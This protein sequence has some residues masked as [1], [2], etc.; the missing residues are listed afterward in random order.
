VG[1]SSALRSARGRPILAAVD[2]RSDVT[3][4]PATAADYEAFARLQPQ[5][6]TGDPIAPFDRF[7]RELAPT[8]LV[9]E[10]AG[11]VVGYSWFEVLAGTGY[12]RHVVVDAESRG[13][14]A[15]RALMLG[16]RARLRAAGCATWCLNVRPDNVPA[17]R[18][19]ESLGLTAA[20]D[21]VALR[22]TWPL[23]DELPLGAPLE[24]VVAP[25]AAQDAAIE[26]AFGLVAG[27]LAAARARAGRVIVAARRDDRLVGAAVFDPSFPGAFPFR[28]L[29]AADARR[30]LEG[31][32]PLARPGVP[33][34]GVVV[35]DHPALE[36]LLLG[37]GAEVRFR[38]VH[39]R[40]SLAAP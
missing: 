7:A 22:F 38:I 16:V 9:A 6:G 11:R 19:Y 36:A 12:V 3:L 28:V 15:G 27:Q 40:G 23:V 21:S 39:H 5:L 30:L 25:G 26:A 4:R 14:G 37:A 2:R 13:L 34:M 33:Q 18:L 20:H 17:R 32:R 24:I 1:A 31:L 10:H 35:E 8:M 29:D